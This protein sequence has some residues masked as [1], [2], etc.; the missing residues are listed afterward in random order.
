MTDSVLQ[1]AREERLREIHGRLRG[2]IPELRALQFDIGRLLLEVSRLGDLTSL[3]TTTFPM[4]CE[5]LGLSPAEGRELPGMV[6]AAEAR[7][8][9][10][11][12]VVEA[13][14]S[15]QKA[16]LAHE[17]MTRPELQRPGEDVLDLLQ[18]K[19]AR[20]ALDEVRRRREEA[21]IAE[22]PVTRTFHFS[23][24]ESREVDRTQELVSRLQGRI[25]SDSEAVAKA[26]GA[27]NDV[28]DPE[29]KALRLKE[30]DEKERGSTAGAGVG[31]C[32]G[33]GEARPLLDLDLDAPGRSR[34]VSG[35]TAREMTRVAGDRC[36]VDGCTFRVFLERAHRRPFR[37][38]G[39]NGPGN[40]LQLCHDHHGGYDRGEWRLVRRSDGGRVMIARDG[41]PAGR[42]REEVGPFLDRFETSVRPKCEAPP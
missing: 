32:V 22:P 23:A 27:F 11:A 24:G 2:R 19:A 37:A 36:W 42:L 31:A 40:L 12:R 8:E 16:T 20:D 4:Y 35:R 5:S 29:R 25:V 41:W 9:V 34:H 14:L 33:A 30:R 3:G 17:V 7:P 6:R 21:R 15:P 39:S 38:N 1:L 10:E 13:R 18:R 28:H 26:C